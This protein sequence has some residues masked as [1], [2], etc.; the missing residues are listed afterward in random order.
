MELTSE[1]VKK[2]LIARV[3]PCRR[4]RFFAIKLLPPPLDDDVNKQTVHR[5]PG[6]FVHSTFRCVLSRLQ[7]KIKPCPLRKQDISFY[8]SRGKPVKKTALLY[9]YGYPTGTVQLGLSF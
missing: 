6:A 1:R 9:D 2:W 3:D 5:L 4:D 8:L 7:C